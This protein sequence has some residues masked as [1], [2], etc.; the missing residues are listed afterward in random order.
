M[1]DRGRIDFRTVPTTVR[2][3]A[4]RVKLRDAI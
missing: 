1:I 3:D 2:V 4:W